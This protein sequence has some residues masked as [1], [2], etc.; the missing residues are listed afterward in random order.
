MSGQSRRFGKQGE[1]MR[2][3]EPLK[4]RWLFAGYAATT[5]NLTMR[6]SV[7][8]ANAALGGQGRVYRGGKLVPG[9]QGTG[10]GGGIYID[11]ATV[12]LDAFTVR[13]TRGNTATT[14]ARDIFGRYSKL[15][16]RITPCTGALRH[17]CER[18]PHCQSSPRL[19]RCPIA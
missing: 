19:P 9:N 1:Y 2:Y 11:K 5:V 10:T 12:G 6:S 14:S 18:I 7:V 4:G 16:E 8:N 15:I 13:N 3:L 17:A